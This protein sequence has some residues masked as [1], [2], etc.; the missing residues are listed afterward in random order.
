M[1]SVERLSPLAARLT[2]RD[3]LADFDVTATVALDPTAPEF[4]VTLDADPARKLS[5]PIRYPLPF[6]SRA[7]D[8]LVLPYA[9]G[10]IVPV[11]ATGP[12][13][14]FKWFEWK[15]GFDYAEWKTS[16]GFGAATDLTSGYAL[17]NE[18]PWDSSLEVASVDGRLAPRMSWRP[19][20]GVFGYARRVLV[21]FAATG[22]HVALAVR[23]RELMRA[24]GWLRTLAEKAK[25]RPAVATLPGAV[26]LWVLDR[27]LPADFLEDL[28]ARG[29]TR[30][31]VSIGGGWEEPGD[32]AGLVRKAAAAGFLPSRY[33]I[34]TDAW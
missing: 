18:T 27:G 33:D 1:I 9:E 32:A 10:L 34:Y 26:D 16:L 6:V 19:Q 13:A 12:G 11:T 22:G 3:R 23:H 4:T 17:L 25:I 7:R 14:G 31:V 20:R 2:L 21:R 29:V 30:A 8:L 15:S 24:K 5:G 28:A